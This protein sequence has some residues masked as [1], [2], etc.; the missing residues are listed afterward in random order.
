MTTDLL[1][2]PTK[3]SRLSLIVNAA[4]VAL[5]FGLLG[6]VLWRNSDDIRKVFS[7]RLDLS[8][9]WWALAIYLVGTVLTFLRWFILVRVIEPKITFRST[10][11]LGSIGMVFNLVIPGAV[12]GD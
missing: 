7:R 11:L 8:L 10:M 12:G 6:L 9:L 4:L 1:A 2:T 3:Q 5:A